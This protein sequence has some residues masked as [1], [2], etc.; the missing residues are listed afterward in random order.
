MVSNNNEVLLLKLIGS[1]IMHKANNFILL[2]MTDL[3]DGDEV[4]IRLKRKKENPDDCKNNLR[5]I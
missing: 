5:D 1:Y 2:E 4:L 3:L